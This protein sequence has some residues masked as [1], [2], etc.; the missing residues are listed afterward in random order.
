MGLRRWILPFVLAAT[1]S[2]E[3]GPMGRPAPP[4]HSQSSAAARQELAANP[5]IQQ[6]S[7]LMSERWEYDLDQLAKRRIV[8]VLV[9]PSRL[10]YFVDR[11]R[12]RGASY[13]AVVEFERMLNAKYKTGALPIQCVF[14]P[15]PRD[16]LLTR[17]ADGRGDLAVGSIPVTP[18]RLR[19]VDFSDPIY[20]GMEQ[21]VVTGPGAPLLRTLGDLSGREVYVR[22]SSSYAETLRRL[23]ELWGSQGIDPVR[24]RPADENL[25]DGDIL[26]LV[27]TGVTPITIVSRGEAK[28]YSSV[29]TDLRVRGDLVLSSG[30]SIAWAMRKNTPLLRA[31]VNEF[32]R[33]HRVGT[34]FGNQLLQRYFRDNEWIKN[35]LPTAGSAR[36]E[37]VAQAV[38]RSG[39]EFDLDPL[40][41]LAQ[42]YQESGLNQNRRSP[43]GAVGVM[44][45]K[46]STAAW[47]PIGIRRVD[48]LDN[49]VR[50]GAKYLR[51][52]I[53]Q[54]FADEE[55]TPLGQQIFAVAS[56]NA[57]PARIERLRQEAA[58][59]G[60]NPNRWFQNVEVM[61]ARDIGRETVD[62]VSNIHKYYLAFSLLS[63]R[64]AARERALSLE[65]AYAQ[66]RVMR[67]PN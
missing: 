7:R 49:N 52:I 33:T 55:M 41:L 48:R 12:Q 22:D 39:A 50:A 29:L 65:R 43:V 11:G 45:I 2:C 60:L 44:Q 46:P 5:A 32:M 58:A 15:V 53:D 67:L 3:A 35:P 23:N 64:N 30:G 31:A 27:N 54:H 66:E 17:L 14:I 56:Y 61:A 47:P 40:L 36:F 4:A 59:V 1:I 25:E 16:E 6:M 51:Y 9:V 34:W 19:L 28:L 37:H 63:Q 26:E 10:L 57:G 20:V 8:R 42:G 13:D 18:E 21:I 24:I 62:Y 38:R